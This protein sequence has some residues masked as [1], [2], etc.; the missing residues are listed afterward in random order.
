MHV[1]VLDR[2]GSG[3]PADPSSEKAPIVTEADLGKRC[4]EFAGT[5]FAHAHDQGVAWHL[6]KKLVL[7]T[8]P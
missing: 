8:L 6:G 4:S 2:A 5:D 1:L 3:R 7:G